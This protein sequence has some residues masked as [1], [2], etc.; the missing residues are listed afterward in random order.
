MVVVV[1][2]GKFG[3]SPRLA[4]GKKPQIT[5]A[6]PWIFFAHV[7]HKRVPLPATTK[8]FTEFGKI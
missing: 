3:A 8:T 1:D 6:M 5:F 2:K 7:D 4:V